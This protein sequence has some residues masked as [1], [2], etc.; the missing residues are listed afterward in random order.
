MFKKNND[1]CLTRSNPNNNQF[2]KLLPTAQFG[3]F[4]ST[5]NKE[6]KSRISHPCGHHL[7]R[8]G[9][10]KGV[11]ILLN[12]LILRQNSVMVILQK[13]ANLNGWPQRVRNIH[14]PTMFFPQETSPSAIPM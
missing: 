11:L 8:V 12:Q 3:G 4:L 6:E 7:P 13:T 10:K 14:T 1:V 2:T 9:G 5:V